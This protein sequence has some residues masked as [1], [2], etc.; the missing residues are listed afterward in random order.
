VGGFVPLDAQKREKCGFG[1]SWVCGKMVKKMEMWKW[2]LMGCRGGD[3]RWCGVMK[4]GWWFLVIG[5]VWGVWEMRENGGKV[6]Y[7]AGLK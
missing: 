1:E 7:G 6:L 2:V 3:G 4:D 5:G